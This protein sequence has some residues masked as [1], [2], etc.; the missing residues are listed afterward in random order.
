MAYNDFCNEQIFVTLFIKKIYSSKNRFISIQ[1]N[2]IFINFASEAFIH[3]CSLS[4]KKG[5]TTPSEA[6]EQCR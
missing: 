6:S 5:I 4:A 1:P 2:D 3:H